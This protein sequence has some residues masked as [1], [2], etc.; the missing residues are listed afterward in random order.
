MF[1]SIAT[2]LAKPVKLLSSKEEPAFRLSKGAD[3]L[4]KGASSK[5]LIS[6]RKPQP[7]IDPRSGVT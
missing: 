5:F 4:A 2:I 6:A 3:F 7:S 1:A